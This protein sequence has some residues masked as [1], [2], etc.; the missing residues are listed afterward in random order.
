MRFFHKSAALLACAVST[1][2][3]AQAALQ[4]SERLGAIGGRVVAEN[5]RPLPRATITVR[6]EDRL[7]L[8]IPS[9]TTGDAEGKFVLAGL[10]PG[11]YAISASKEDEFYPDTAYSFYYSGKP[12]PQ[13]TVSAG[14]LTGGLV[15]R[16]GPKGARITG[17]VV[18]ATTGLPLWKAHVTFYEPRSPQIYMSTTVKKG[19]AEFNLLV[20]STK[21]FRMRASAPGFDTWYFGTVSTE[22]EA[23]PI[24][25]AP[26][27][28]KELV[29]SL[30]PLKKE[31][32]KQPGSPPR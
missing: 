31:S 16:L 32:Q 26:G 15:V 9:S 5:G 21:P 3:M 24:Q 13:V 27:T 1:I 25:L 6:R 11:L 23:T 7:V 19:T 28:T 12:L 18:D 2:F 20:P 22:E 29:I 17:R 10:V 30:A 14:N 8:G 4:A